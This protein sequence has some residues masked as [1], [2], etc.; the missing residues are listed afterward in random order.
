MESID[1]FFSDPH[2]H[3]KWYSLQFPWLHRV[4]LRHK[5]ANYW[6]KAWNFSLFISFFVMDKTIRAQL[7]KKLLLDKSAAWMYLSIIKIMKTWE[8][9]SSHH[10]A[11]PLILLETIISVK[12]KI[13]FIILNFHFKSKWAC[14]AQRYRSKDSL[15]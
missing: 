10:S 8:L 5:T 14:Q 9:K 15:K 6:F 1:I 4:R 7:F 12:L 13:I 11:A 3:N 2:Q